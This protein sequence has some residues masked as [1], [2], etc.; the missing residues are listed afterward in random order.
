MHFQTRSAS[1]TASIY[2][3]SSAHW[4]SNE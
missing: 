2:R 4:Q 3:A 1:Y